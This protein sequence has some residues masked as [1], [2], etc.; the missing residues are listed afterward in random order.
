MK[1][2]IGLLLLFFVTSFQSCVVSK[3]FFCTINNEEVIEI[4][5]G[6]AGV[7]SLKLNFNDFIN[8]MPDDEKKDMFGSF[9]IK[10]DTMVFFNDFLS[11]TSLHLNQQENIMFKDGSAHFEVDFSKNEENVTVKLFYYNADQLDFIRVHIFDFIGNNTD[12]AFSMLKP[13][14]EMG[15]LQK[16]IYA[17][18]GIRGPQIN[19]NVKQTIS[20][21]GFSDELPA[22][23]VFNPVGQTFTLRIMKSAVQNDFTDKALFDKAIAANESLKNIGDFSSSEKVFFK[24]TFITPRPVKNYK[25]SSVTISADKKTI[26]FKN[27]LRDIITKPEKTAY[28]ISF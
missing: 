4:L 16:Q 22:L 25:G 28:S 7:Y 21:I 23:K 11:D 15:D 19:F 2:N 17:M 12:F 20:P 8:M 27:S 5:Q 24:T 10:L 9:G 18:L 3:T 1:K 14:S 26:T 13:R 6:D